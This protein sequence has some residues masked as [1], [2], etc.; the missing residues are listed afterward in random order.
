MSKLQLLSNPA[1]PLRT[2]NSRYRSGVL[3][4][5]RKCE[6]KL[7]RSGEHEHTANLKK[8]LRKLAKRAG[9][10]VPYV[11]PISCLKLCP[12]GAV[13]V[14]TQRDLASL[15]PSLT[16][17]R[18]RTDVATLFRIVTVAPTPPTPDQP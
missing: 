5:C 15:P 4:V 3:L 6:R 10:E 16:L 17:I 7:K 8:S 2:Y 1:S 18:T 11:I 12:K 14:C 13:T 9:T